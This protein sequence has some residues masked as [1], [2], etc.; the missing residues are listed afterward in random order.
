LGRTTST[1]WIPGP[2]QN[3]AGVV[4]IAVNGNESYAVRG[5]DGAINHEE[6]ME[7]GAR[8]AEVFKDLLRRIISKI[9]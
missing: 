5:S 4:N 8:V 9:A 6:V 2:V 7:T 3:V 1:P